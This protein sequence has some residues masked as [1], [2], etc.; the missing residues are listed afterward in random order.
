MENGRTI[1]DYH[2]PS[3]CG[4]GEEGGQDDRRAQKSGS[5]SIHPSTGSSLVQHDD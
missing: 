4:F 5:L 2:K 1:A 3:A